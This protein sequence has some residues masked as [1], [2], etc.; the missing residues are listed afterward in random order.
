VYPHSAERR[1]R[2]AGRIETL[3]VLVECLAKHVHL[4]ALLG[5]LGRTHATRRKS[6]PVKRVREGGSNPHG[7]CPLDPKSPDWFRSSLENPSNTGKG[8]VF[9]LPAE[10]RI[11]GRKRKVGTGFGSVPTF[12]Q[13]YPRDFLSPS[14]AVVYC[15]PHYVTALA[16]T[17]N[18]VE[19]STRYTEMERQFQR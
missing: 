13:R 15:Q 11:A 6:L 8:L 18:Q 3:Q 14:H 12:C 17:F 16:G 5:L 9:R 2:E 4:T 7:L 1:P 10:S 19:M